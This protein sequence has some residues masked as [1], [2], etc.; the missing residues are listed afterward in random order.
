MYN[1]NVEDMK[2]RNS[3]PR[4]RDLRYI[5]FGDMWTTSR[6]DKI[7]FLDR[8]NDGKVSYLLNLADKFRDDEPNMKRDTWNNV[9][10][11]SLIAWLKRNDDRKL[12]DR[13]YKHGKIYILGCER[14]IQH[15]FTKDGYDRY[16]DFVDE[17][18]YRQ[19]K[20]CLQ[21]EDQYF[22]ETD[23]YEIMKST[24]RTYSEKY[25]TTFGMNLGFVSNGQIII[26]NDNV[27]K[28]FRDVEITA[29]QCQILIDAYQDLESE[30]HRLT[31]VCN[32]RFAE[33]D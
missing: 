14:W 16:D 28:R 23:S 22:K 29:K 31:G 12:I 7:E 17:L 20:Q 11:Q 33:L 27:D 26:R 9:R 18:F 2:L 6:E 13:D 25:G 19:L 5:D 30:I 4:N 8:M 32:A 15:G 3:Q 24:I 21:K 10:T 1:W